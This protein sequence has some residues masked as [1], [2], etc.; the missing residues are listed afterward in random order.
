MPTYRIS[1]ES[2]TFSPM[3]L[4]ELKSRRV[5]IGQIDASPILRELLGP[6]WDKG[7]E[8]FPGYDARIIRSQ[9]P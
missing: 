9:S 6:D 1:A 8:S 4:E 2:L 3:T 7:L 5:L